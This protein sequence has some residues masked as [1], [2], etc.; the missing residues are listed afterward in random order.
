MLLTI[1]FAFLITTFPMNIAL[2]STHFYSP[3]SMDRPA[4][5]RFK[6]IRAITEL[7]MYVNHSMN[8]YLYCATGHKFRQ[9]LLQM[10][11]KCSNTDNTH[12]LTMSGVYNG[13]I[14]GKAAG[15]NMRTGSTCT[16]PMHR[17]PLRH[18]NNSVTEIRKGEYE[19]VRGDPV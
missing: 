16:L 19:L 13:N 12:E 9:Q 8:F 3:I 5:A 4:M 14:S 1:S 7:L 17:S 10:C 11:C 2:I 6:L 15:G 18:P